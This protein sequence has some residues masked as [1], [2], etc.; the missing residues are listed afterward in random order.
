MLEKRVKSR[1]SHRKLDVVLPTGL[2]PRQLEGPGGSTVEED[3]MLDVLKVW[4][5]SGLRVTGHR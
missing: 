1:F 4:G 5:C 2:A 3:G